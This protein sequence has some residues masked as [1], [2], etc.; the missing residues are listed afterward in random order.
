MKNN[1]SFNDMWISPIYTSTTDNNKVVLQ[2]APFKRKLQLSVLFTFIF[3]IP[4]IIFGQT[5]KIKTTIYFD[6]NKY[7]IRDDGY[8]TLNKITDTLAVADIYR[9]V[10][11]GNTDNTADSLYNVKLST[12]R[13][14]TVKN[15]FVEIGVNKSLILTNYFGEDKPIASNDNDEG[16][17][18]NRRVDIFIY[19]KHKILPKHDTIVKPLIVK[20]TSNLDTTI[21]LPQGTSLVFNRN[22]YLELKDC[23]EYTETNNP[24]SILAN[25]ISL[26]DNNGIPISSCGM[27][28]VSLK[29]G[30]TKR[31]CFKVPVKVRFPVPEDNECDYCGRNARVF[32]IT[33]NGSWYDNKSKKSE[34][35]II[36]V[37]GKSYYQ[38]DMYCPNYW[39]NCDCKV[40]GPKLKFKIKKPYKIVSVKVTFDCP[41]TVLNI[42]PERRA[43]KVM[44][45]IPCWRGAKTVLATIIDDKG[46]T[47]L[48]QEQP[49]N[50]LPKRTM[51]S[52]CGKIENKYIGYR[53]GIFKIAKRER[54]RKYI[55][56]PE[57]LIKKNKS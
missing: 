53:F 10:I 18:K 20:D 19:T 29:P 15:Y 56:R 31:D 43:N 39:K 54:Y 40:K 35:K 32:D 51:F 2:Q 17:Q 48:L 46:D 23:L 44:I 27:L 49:L 8:Q 42:K 33:T 1:N 14:E 37:K 26:M 4:L 21:Y 45:K 16:K 9:V 5:Q 34:V 7:D 3:F 52:R 25:G 55:I 50:D 24:Q 6:N 28:K 57:F 38:F 41:T 13:A 22:E 47:L 30:C 11:N 12:N 36:K